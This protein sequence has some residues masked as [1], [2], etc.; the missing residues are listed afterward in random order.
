MA[1]RTRQLHRR[2]VPQGHPASGDAVRQAGFFA[3]PVCAHVVPASGGGSRRVLR[4]VHLSGPHEPAYRDARRRPLPGQGEGAEVLHRIRHLGAGRD[5]HRRLRRE[6]RAAASD[7]AEGFRGAE[8]A[9]ERGPFLHLRLREAAQPQQV[10]GDPHRHFVG[11]GVPRSERGNRGSLEHEGHLQRLRKL[12][13][14]EAP[15]ADRDRDRGPV[16]AG[17]PHVSGHDGK[18][19][20]RVHAGRV[21]GGDLHDP[22]EGVPQGAGRV[23]GDAGRAAQPGRA[24]KEARAAGAGDEGEGDGGGAAKGGGEAG[25]AEARAA[26]TA[27]EKR[28]R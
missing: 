8:G 6:R 23:L 10:P 1:K 2:N 7:P 4:L 15:G 3:A 5:H 11:R 17:G 12:R 19:H 18:Q 16:D 25:A 22:A 13:R 28:R 9:A 26:A 21:G 20:A 27:G 24:P 14:R